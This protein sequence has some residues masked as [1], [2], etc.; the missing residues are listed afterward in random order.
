MRMTRGRITALSVAL[1]ATVVAAGIG[2]NIVAG[3]QYLAV[4]LPGR[5]FKVE[6]A[7]R[8]LQPIHLSRAVG[9]SAIVSA[10]L[11]PWNS[12]GAFMAAT[13][14][15]ATLDFLP[16]AFFNLVNPLFTIAAAFLIGRTAAPAMAG[17][18]TS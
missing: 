10:P 13:L 18:G 17:G 14:G 3:D 16:Y 12:C 2:M 1:V 15:V 5:M 9:D 7:R 4:V 11:V 6:F 8:G